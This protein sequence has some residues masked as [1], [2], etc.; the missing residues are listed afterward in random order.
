MLQRFSKLIEKKS[1]K[2]QWI[3]KNRFY[4]FERQYSMAKTLFPI[5]FIESKDNLVFRI[6]V[7]KKGLK[8]HIDV[9]VNEYLDL[10][11]EVQSHYNW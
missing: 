4:A 9:F 10:S 5:E 2:Q 6:W 1:A 11:F 8:L 7:I 3:L